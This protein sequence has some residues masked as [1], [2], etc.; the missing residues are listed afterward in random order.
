MADVLGGHSANVQMGSPPAELA[1]Q[2]KIEGSARD[3]GADCAGCPE[4]VSIPGGRF[5]MGSPKS[6]QD[7]PARQTPLHWVSIRPFALGKYEVT[8]DEW[9]LCVSEGLCKSDDQGIRVARDL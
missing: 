3:L 2:V 5:T 7:R 1:P 6:E 4:M 9:E 8:W